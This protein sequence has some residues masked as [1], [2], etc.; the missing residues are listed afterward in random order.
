RKY[1]SDKVFI[2]GAYEEVD[3]FL[4]EVGNEAKKLADKFCEKLGKELFNEGV[5]TS[6]GLGLG[7]GR[8][9][10]TGFLKE[11]AIRGSTRLTSKLIIRPFPIMQED[12]EKRRYRK[13][14]LSECGVSIFLFGNKYE[15][16]KLIASPGVR[17]EY[18]ISRKLAHFIIRVATSGYESE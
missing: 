1:L 14:I 18:E 5:Q 11:E 16:D 10:V 15:G 6:S 4:G 9:L 8:N 7:V 17:E 12:E 3:R 13:R 2:S